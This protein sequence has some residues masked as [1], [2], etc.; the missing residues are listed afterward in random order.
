MKSE[1]KDINQL[2]LNE[3]SFGYEERLV[4]ER[5]NLGLMKGS[6]I[7]IVGPNGSG[8]STLI[9]LMSAGLKPKNGVVLIDGEK[10]ES[11][12]KKELAKKIS[13]VPQTIPSDVPFT[14]REVVLMARY[15]YL[16]RLSSESKIDYEIVEQAMKYT[17]TL[18]FSDRPMKTLSG[19]ERQRVILAQALA[20]EPEIM[21][22]DEPVS[23]LDLLHQVEILN[24]L[25]RL[26]VERNITVI[27]ILHDL[28]MATTYSDF[29][30]ILK[31]KKIAAQG[32]PEDIFTVERIKDV[33]DIDVTISLSPV[34]HK[35]Y[36]YTHISKKVDLNGYKI[37]VLCGGGSGSG[38]IKNL[39]NDGFDVSV[40][41]LSAGDMDWQISKELN[42]KMTEVIPF[43]TISREA[44]EKNLKL[45]EIA[46]VIILAPAYFGKANK[47]N[48]EILCE[49][50]LKNKK[51]II[52]DL[53][54]ISERDFSG[55][56]VTE[57]LLKIKERTTSVNSEKELY[58]VMR[59]YIE[60]K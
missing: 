53:E 8:K 36:I 40:G 16:R 29:A 34:T 44:Y 3:I 45:C 17:D 18:E 58:L 47:L 41:V 33:F 26:C 7:S 2:Q 50:S 57:K 24:L 1:N 22:L 39:V 32:I 10:I 52:I 14:S 13:F 54:G 46:D 37:H 31:E 20:Q 21:L 60:N 27:A 6:F 11:L 51:K 38:I 5:I 56:E 35:P 59:D 48:A 43:T 15:P 49:P 19:G 55:G 30:L 25:K 9:R 28:N 12:G 23:N 4:L 42:L